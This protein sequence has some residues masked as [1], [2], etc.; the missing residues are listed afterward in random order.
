M[1]PLTALAPAA[2]M[3][4]VLGVAA[5][6][7]TA[8]ATSSPA[9][10]APAKAASKD[11]PAVAPRVETPALFDDEAGG[12]AN[13]DDPAIWVH[14]TTPA[15]SVV[16]TTAKEGGLYV[17]DLDGRQLQ[18]IPAPPAPGEDDEPGRLNN[19]DVVYGSPSAA[20]RPDLLVASDRGSDKLRVYRVDPGE[21]ARGREPLTDVTDPSAPFIFN[22]TQTEVNDA[23]TVYGLATWKRASGTYVVVSRRHTTRL[24]LLKLVDAPHGKVGY[25]L[26]RTIDLPSSFTLPDGGRWSPCDEPGV[27]PQV[28]GMVVDAETGTLYA[29]QEDVGVWRM[30]ADLT[31]RPAL[32]DRVREFGVP[33]TFDAATEECVP[34][35]DPGFGGHH[36]AAD[37]EGLTIYYGK[38]GKGYLI[39][40]S[41]GDDTFS[42]YGRS[43]A[44][45][46]IG[47]FQVGDHGAVD[48]VQA[49]DGAM[50][51]NVPLGRSFP[52]GLFVTHD[53]ANTPEAL[54]PE[55]EERE[56]TDFK[57]V[58]WD[59]IAG[60][61][62]L[63]VD[64]RSWNPRR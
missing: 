38:N 26:L 4:G 22:A 54:D 2:L 37:A 64:T 45:A 41:Q 48:G 31:G 18:H 43:G 8:T 47:S 11:L 39:A 40:S 34:G 36:L 21:A 10:K 56:N 63:D 20:G 49:S 24:A 15:R 53:G 6:P 44:N 14:P 50:V 13:G 28:E 12:N 51:V 3:I 60:R 1:R 46:Y 55:G 5:V 25:K 9:A 17:Y 42:V 30:P 16:A 61:L 59:D 27:G 33:A 35:A 57:Y 52:K 29:A 19:V 32:I 23:E 62:G 7:A 58:K